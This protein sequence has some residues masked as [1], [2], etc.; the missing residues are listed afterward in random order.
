MKLHSVALFLP[1]S[2]L[3][4]LNQN[5]SELVQQCQQIYTKRYRILVNMDTNQ[6]DIRKSLSGYQTTL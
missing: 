4:V 1:A 5:H 3:I 6:A 2:S